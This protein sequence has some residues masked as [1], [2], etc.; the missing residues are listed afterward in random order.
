MKSYVQKLFGV[1]D[2]K[3]LSFELAVRIIELAVDGADVHLGISALGE[4]LVKVA[5]HFTFSRFPTSCIC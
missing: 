4:H 5:P 2:N 3:A 1:A